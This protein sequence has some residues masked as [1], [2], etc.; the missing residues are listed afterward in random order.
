MKVLFIS[1]FYPPANGGLG[2]MQLCEEVADGLF[3]L[4]HDVAVLT[5]TQI[6]GNEPKRGYPVYRKLPISP[7]FEN[8]QPI[9]QQFFFGRRQKEF[10]AIS[11]F[12]QIIHDHAPEVIFVWHAIGLPKVLFQEA[13]SSSMHEVVYYLADYQPEIGDEYISY[14]EGKPANPVI[15]LLKGSLAKY[16]LKKLDSEGKPITLDYKQTICV[17]N[18]VRDRLVFGGFIPSS[19]VVIHNGVDLSEFEASGESTS[20]SINEELR[21]LVAGRI[22]PNKGIHT[23]IDAFASLEYQELPTNL[24]LTILGDGPTNYV[25]LIHNKIYQNKLQDRITIMPPI[26]RSEMPGFLAE[27]NVL[28]LASEY[29]EPLAR[30]IQ[31]AMAMGLLVIGTTTG[32]SGEL[33]VNNQTGLVFETGSYKSL[34]DQINYAATNPELMEE[35]QKAGKKA[36]AD[37]FN[38]QRTVLE[39]EK[40]LSRV[41]PGD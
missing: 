41:I 28:I 11:D 39:I 26:P 21:C 37:N 2:Y 38:I 1:N 8:N 33:L 30:S 32:G 35:L 7:D 15:R 6:S 4:G 17:S 3:A 19:A 24:S 9:P 34:A 36:I 29:D 27:Y 31:E 18:Y 25:N 13:E 14:W 12:R 23:I 22:I 20:I 5:S 10:Q 16:A 40:Y